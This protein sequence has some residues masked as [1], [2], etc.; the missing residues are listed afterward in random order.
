VNARWRA[1]EGRSLELAEEIEAVNPLLAEHLRE[2]VPDGFGNADM[3]VG[4]MRDALSVIAERM[5]EHA[6]EVHEIVRALDDLP[7]V[8]GRR[9]RVFVTRTRDGD[10]TCGWE[11]EDW[12]ESAEPETFDA[13]MQWARRRSDDIH[14]SE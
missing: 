3:H 6:S 10:Y 4:V 9:G 12:L 7:S 1:I 5:P 14:V 8:I 2:T 11:D 13:A